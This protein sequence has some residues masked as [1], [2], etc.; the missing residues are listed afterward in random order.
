MRN[1]S[2]FSNWFSTSIAPS[3]FAPPNFWTRNIFPQPT[4]T[5]DFLDEGKENLRMRRI[6]WIWSNFT[7]T[8]S[9]IGIPLIWSM[10]CGRLT[11][12][13]WGIG[14]AWLSCS[15]TM[16]QEKSWNLIDSYHKNHSCGRCIYFIYSSRCQTAPLHNPE[17]PAQFGS[18]YCT[19]TYF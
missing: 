16:I 17:K 1:A 4:R 15:L 8:L 9:F 18:G 6:W 11:H 5:S 14:N 7:L 19:I 3:P 13:C 10:L 2:K 12:I